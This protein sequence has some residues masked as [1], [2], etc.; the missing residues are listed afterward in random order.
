M[1]VPTGTELKFF[2]HPALSLITKLSYTCSTVFTVHSSLIQSTV[3][4]QAFTMSGIL[5]KCGC[6]APRILDILKPYVLNREELLCQPY[7]TAAITLGREPPAPGH[8]LNMQTGIE[9]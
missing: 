8:M 9:P 7:S 3:Y 6:K 1:V 4:V 2:T 5:I